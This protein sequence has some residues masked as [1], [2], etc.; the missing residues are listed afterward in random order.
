[1]NETLGAAF[2]KE[3]EAEAASTRKC[4]EKIPEALFGWKPHQ[5]SMTMGYLALLV[6]EIPKWITHMVEKGDIDFA[7]F[8][9]FQPKTTAEL[10]N[11]FD[12]N[13]KGAK[14]ALRNV[15]NEEL[16]KTFSL[17]NHGQVLFSSP[18]KENIGSSIN[19]L[20]HHRG[21]LTVYMRL[22]NLPVPSIY[23]PSADEKGF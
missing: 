22:N 16:A 14:N 9:H 1:M 7:T 11:H 3:L 21:Q 12:E 6:A 17:K 10:V 2:L 8:E 13:L 5:K 15:S 4:L 19:H 23:G 18:I 20:V